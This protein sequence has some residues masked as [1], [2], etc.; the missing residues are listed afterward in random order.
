[1]VKFI[2][3]AIGF[4]LT[5]FGLV[6]WGDIFVPVAIVLLGAHI[7]YV[8]DKGN[9]EIALIVI[10]AIIG[11]VVDSTLQVLGVFNFFG[12]AYLPLWLISL[13]FC[14]GATLH[15]SLGFLQDSKRLQ[16]LVGAT[17][18]PLSYL[19]GN[20]LEAVDFGISIFSTYMVLSLVW[21]VLMV[22]FFYIKFL[23]EKIKVS[24]G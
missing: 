10:V 1:M 6:Y 14:F 16:F 20:Q 7:I 3:N 9:H 19:A 8:S 11:V 12:N 23:L 2:I 22:V 18:A 4:N 24:Y 15:H 21:A 13:W 5:W 17:I